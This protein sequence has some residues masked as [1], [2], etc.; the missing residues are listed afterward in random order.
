MNFEQ[1]LNQLNQWVWGPVLIGL[2]I[3]TGIFL[4]IILKGLQF[5]KLWHALKLSVSPSEEAEGDITPFESFTTALSATVGTGNIA[6]VATAITIGGLGAIFWMWVS[7]VVGMVLMYSESLL[8]VRFRRINAVHQ[9]SGGPMYYLEKGLGWKWLG[10]CFAIFGFFASLGVG[11]LVQ[12]HSIADVVHH[13]FGVPIWITGVALALGVASIV[14]GGIKRVGKV[15]AIVVPAMA[16][17]YMLAALGVILMHASILP[18]A[19]GRIVEA[20]FTGQAAVGGF[21]GATAMMAMRMGIARG[22]FSNEA[23]MGTAGIAA[24]AART[25]SPARQALI[26]M[27]GPLIDT[28]IVC[29][30]TGLVLAVTGVLGTVDLDGAPLTA[31]A[32]QITLPGGSAMVAISLI[33]F[34][35]STILGWAFYG[36]KCVEYLLGE[37]SRWFYRIFFCLLVGFGVALP[38]R[39]VWSFADIANGLMAFT[40]LVGILG[41]A[42]IVVS[43]TQI[44]FG[45]RHA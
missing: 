34:A 17:F 7:G 33:F 42:G 20:A 29:T 44:Y 40:N 1:V 15:T 22:L 6:G 45:K 4:T 27:C 31:Y 30:L 37:R 39:A 19:I 41:L 32:F 13:T 14:V 18:A 24:A 16:L 28:L 11:N 12:S 38:L 3:G 43:E 21:A 25:S 5:R 26:N 35:S 9:M 10:I 2:L 8:A 36:E 23:G